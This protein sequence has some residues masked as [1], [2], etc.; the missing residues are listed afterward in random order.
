M[1][2][3][4]GTDGLER[5]HTYIHTYIH[6]HIEPWL[7]RMQLLAGTEGLERMHK[8][9]VLLVGIGGVGG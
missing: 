9:N 8:A 1:Q 5:I 7:E 4:A 3:V 2:V 6:T